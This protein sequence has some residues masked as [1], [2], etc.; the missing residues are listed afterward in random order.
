MA[1]YYIQDDYNTHAVELPEWIDLT[2]PNEE[3]IV[4]N[5]SMDVLRLCKLLKKPNIVSGFCKHIDQLK[6]AIDTYRES[7]KAEIVDFEGDE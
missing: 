6:I 3:D 7:I 4:Y 1:T 5:Y 2:D